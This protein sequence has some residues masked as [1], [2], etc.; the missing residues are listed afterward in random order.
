MDKKHN[1]V[2]ELILFATGNCTL[3]WYL[4]YKGK[5]TMKHTDKKHNI[6][7]RMEKLWQG[8]VCFFCSWQAYGDL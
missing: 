6:I 5:K 3:Y 7:L 4:L 1:N 2:S 8:C